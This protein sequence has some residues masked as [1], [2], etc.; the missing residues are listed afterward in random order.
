[1]ES[2]E[3]AVFALALGAK[4]FDRGPWPRVAK[5][6]NASNPSLRLGLLGIDPQLA[7][8]GSMQ[9]GFEFVEHL[10]LLSLSEPKSGPS[11]VKYAGFSSSPGYQQFRFIS[12]KLLNRMDLTGTFRFLEREIYL[13]NAVLQALAVL[14]HRKPKL[15]VF[16]V[17]PHEFVPFVIQSV[18]EWL[19]ISVLFFQPCSMAPTMLARTNLR[20]VTSPKGAEVAAS[21]IAREICAFMPQRLKLLIEGLDPKYIQQQRGRD[22]TASSPF[23]LLKSV[24]A[25]LSWLWKDRFPRS[26]DFTGHAGLDGVMGR[27]AKIILFRSLQSTLRGKVNSLGSRSLPLAPYCVLA[28]HYEPERTSVPEGFPIDFQGDAVVHSRLLVPETNALVV[29]EHYSQQTSA[30]R[31]VAGRSPEFYDLVESMPNTWF[32]PTQSRLSELV[33]GAECVITLTGTVAIESVLR[34]VPVAYFGSPWWEGL[35]GTVRITDAFSYDDVRGLKLPDQGDVADFLDNLCSSPMIPGL[36]GESIETMEYRLGPL[37][38]GFFDAVAN[39]VSLCV[40][41]EMELT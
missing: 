23:H 18:A 22:E 29:K 9:G 3:L 24:P 20:A 27:L 38:Q 4:D 36:A 16:D 15:L 8:H 31:G 7:P 2:N 5:I 19:G 12:L 14:L 35:P 41:R 34:G 37:P 11:L 33:S 1:M 21:P 17:T 6:L 40:R 30:M 26:R 25:T 10:K 13:Q 39:S 32:A 28:L